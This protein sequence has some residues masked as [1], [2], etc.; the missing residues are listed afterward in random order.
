MPSN[1]RHSPGDSPR[2]NRVYN[3]TFG[4]TQTGINMQT[5]FG[6]AANISNQSVRSITTTYNA[7]G[8]LLSVNDPS[9]DVS[10]VRDNLGRA[11]TVSSTVNGV[12][13]SMGQSFD[14]VGNRTE[15]RASG[16]GTPDFRNIYRYDK[17]NRLTEVIQTNQVG[18]SLPSSPSRRRR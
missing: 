17:L 10:F 12:G 7:A 5:F 15:L 3:I 1:R 2:T 14:I 4:G 11:T 18:V 8:E 9:S 6:D 13:F 16:S